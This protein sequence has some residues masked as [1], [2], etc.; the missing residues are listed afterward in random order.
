MENVDDL[1]SIDLVKQEIE[2]HIQD[3]NEE[4]QKVMKN[5]LKKKNS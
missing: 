1:D 4:L 5:L 3:E 2:K